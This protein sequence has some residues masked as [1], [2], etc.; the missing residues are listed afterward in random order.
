MRKLLIRIGLLGI[1]GFLL[2]GCASMQPLSNYA[3]SGDT[4]AISLGGTDSNALVSVLKKENIA[5]TIT[6]SGSVSHPVKLR[7]VIRLYSDPTSVYDYQN[8]NPSNGYT[9]SY[10][11]SHQGLWLAVLDLV[12]PSTG[13]PLPLAVGQASLSISSPDI[14]NW[15]DTTGYGW[16][17]TNGN[18]SNI[19]IEILTGAGSPNPLNYLGPMSYAPMTNL[20]AADQLEVTVQGTPG[21]MIGGAAFVF[22]YENSSFDLEP[23]VTTTT[24]DRN[25]QLAWESMDQGDG[26][27]LLTVTMVNPHGFNVGNNNNSIKYNLGSS[28]LRSLRFNIVWVGSVVTN[29]D[30]QD[31]IQLVS[32]EY[33]NLQGDLMPEL[34]ASVQKVK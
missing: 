30:W 29:A 26:T 8:L 12:D 4:V 2:G 25:V 5:V 32:S 9:A 14:Q 27:S 22:Q 19:P 13:T 17:W 15:F 24:P 21:G 1:L 18:L 28:L 6:D 11:D 31:H 33:S 34:M 23:R 7:N 16:T 20:Q 10:T 3:R